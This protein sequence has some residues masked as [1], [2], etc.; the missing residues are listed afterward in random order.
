SSLDDNQVRRYRT[1]FTREQIGR[2]EKE[3]L[4]ENYVSRPKRCELAV[5]LNLP[6]A[7]IKVWFQNRRMKDKR[8]RMAMAWPYG[9]ADPHLYAYLAAAAASYPYGIPPSPHGC[10][11]PPGVPLSQT[12]QPFSPSSHLPMSS[13]VRPAPVSPS[14]FLGSYLRQNGVG[15]FGIGAPHGS[16]HPNFPHTSSPLLRS[17]LDPTAMSLLAAHASSALTS[18]HLTSPHFLSSL[19]SVRLAAAASAS[20]NQSSPFPHSPNTMSSNHQPGLSPANLRRVSSPIHAPVA[21]KAVNSP[22]TSSSSA[23]GLFR[24]FQTDSERN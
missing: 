16:P 8:Q 3:F 1:A 4:K 7:T 15:A 10:Y 17:P 22:S 18:T 21:K 2:L 12:P 19:D 13:T 23:K 9:I 11:T 20:S 5:S 24:P 6:E 14:D